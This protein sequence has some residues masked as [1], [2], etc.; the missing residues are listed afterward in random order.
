[1]RLAASLA[2]LLALIPVPLS[3]Q[4]WFTHRFGELRANHGDWLAVCSE[5]GAGACRIVAS[6]KDEGSEAFFDHRMSLHFRDN[7]GAWTIEVMDRGMPDRELTFVGFEIDGTVTDLPD[8]AWQ[9]G[10]RDFGNVIETIHL[11][12]PDLTRDLVAAMR[13]GNRLTVRY[14]PIGQDGLA[15]FSLRGITA[16][17]NAVEAHVQDRSN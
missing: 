4:E 16:A 6:G 15:R 10:E 1:M 7:R 11:V 17:M 2:A 3:A 12:D 5:N 13:A 14:L 9:P 8:G